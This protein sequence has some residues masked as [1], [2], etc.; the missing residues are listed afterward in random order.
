MLSISAVGNAGGAAS[1]YTDK[2]NYYFLGENST[3][4]FGKGAEQ[5]GLSGEKI[6]TN[7]FQSVLEG[8]LPDGGDL[9]FMK[10][11]A[12]I[13][14]GGYDLTFSAPKSVS[15]LA[16][17]E[18]EKD[19]LKAHQE[20]VRKTLG[21]I[22]TLFSTRSMVNGVPIQTQTGNM[23]GALFMHDTSRNLDP[24]LHT[25]AVIANATFDEI[26]GRWKTLSSDRIKSQNFVETD[27]TTNL[28]FKEKI[29]FGTIYRQFLKEE[30]VKQGYEIEVVG[31]N[32]LWEIKGVPTEIFSSRR[33]EILEAAR[34]NASAKSL[35]ITAQDTR[36]AKDFSNIEEVR[37]EW[38]EKLAETGFNLAQIRRTEQKD[39]MGN[40]TQAKPLE[41]SQNVKEAVEA[42][43]SSLE[44][45]SIKFSYSEILTRAMNRVEAKVGILA[46]VQSEVQK[47]TQ[48]GRIL[49]TDKQ[50]SIY[51]S[52][53]HLENERDV[54]IQA[55]ELRQKVSGIHEHGN[56]VI[57]MHLSE[58]QSQFTLFTIRGSNSYE[59]KVLNDLD[60]V[61]KANNQQPI[62]VTK[63]K[64]TKFELL[65][66]TEGKGDIYTLQ[67]YLQQDKKDK[68]RLVSV[69]Q[70]EKISLNEMK[71]LLSK[72][73]E[74]GD[75]LAV[76]DT[77]GRRFSGITRDV[78]ESAGMES[79][80]LTQSGDNNRL[81]VL[82]GV[83]KGDQVATAVKAYT[84][85]L[86]G[87]KNTILQTLNA[88]RAEVTNQV[89]EALQDYGYLSNNGVLLSTRESVYISDYQDRSKYKVG[90]VLEKTVQGKTETYKISGINKEKN[91]LILTAENGTNEEQTRKISL[92]ELNST[93]KVYQEK[94][95]DVRVGEHLKATS[96]F[97]ST[98]V[99]EELV[100]TGIKKGNF[101]FKEKLVLED[102]K[103]RE[104]KVPTDKTAYLSYNYVETHGSSK[105]QKR[106][107]IVA[108]VNQKD[109]STGMMTEIR[110]GAKDVLMITS[111]NSE[112]VQKN[113][114]IDDAKVTITDNLKT[115]FDAK[116]L[117][118]IQQASITKENNEL[119]RIV[120]TSIEKAMLETKD[121]VSFNAS[122]VE[123][124]V[125]SSTSFT[126]DQ[127][128]SYF[129]SRIE[130]GELIPLSQDEGISLNSMFVPLSG[131]RT[132]QAILALAAEQKGKSAP[133]LDKNNIGL[134]QE[135]VKGLTE[136]QKNYVSMVLTSQDGVSGVQGFPGVG[137]THALKTL[138]GLAEIYQPELE[139][140]ALSPTHQANKALRDA[141]IHEVS[142][143]QSFLKE[144]SSKN[145]SP[146]AFDKQF[147]VIDESSML[148]NKDLLA[149]MKVITE[150]GGRVTFLGDVQQL[151]SIESGTPLALL[152]QRG[153]MD[154]TEITQ[155][156]RQTQALRPV[157]EQTIA[158]Q[159][160][161]ALAKLSTISPD[162]V[163]RIEPQ[164][165]PS[166][167]VMN[168]EGEIQKNGK[169][170]EPKADLNAETVK[171]F[172]SRTPEARK[173]TLIVVPTNKASREINNLIHEE[174]VAQGEVTRSINVPTLQ[175]VNI[176]KADLQNP[177]TWKAYQDYTA[178]IGEQYYTV[179][180]VDQQGNVQII[181]QRTGDEKYINSYH[182]NAENAA[183]YQPFSIEVG[184]GDKVR[185]RITDKE[186]L[187]VNNSIGEVLSTEDGKLLINV[188][189]KQLSYDPSQDM[190]DRHFTL[191][192]S[193]TIYSSQG[194]NAQY[195]I[196]VFPQESTRYQELDS[197]LVAVSRGKE[198]IQVMS[199]DLTRLVDK[200]HQTGRGDR[201]TSLDLVEGREAEWDKIKED[202]NSVQEW[203][204]MVDSRIEWRQS[205]KLNDKAYDG[206]S[207]VVKESARYNV[208]K[209][210]LIF[211]VV[212]GEGQHQGNLHIPFNPMQG[213]L[214][215]AETYYSGGSD[216]SIVVLHKGDEQS[217]PKEYAFSELKEAIL[218]EGE[219][220]TVLLRL[221]EK[222][223]PITIALIEEDKVNTHIEKTLDEEKQSEQALDLR[224]DAEIQN[225]E[226]VF[227]NERENTQ[228]AER[229][230]SE[231]SRL[232]NDETNIVHHTKEN[233]TEEPRV[234][235][236]QEKE[237]L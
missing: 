11:G 181:D 166:A 168:F 23:L 70:S 187:V 221:P 76:L 156:V 165:M 5:L 16:L 204:K 152:L 133:I 219:E 88:K 140:K 119:E 155:I 198:H 8:K 201:A 205:L 36:Q 146:N 122:A 14:Q 12:N 9:S 6:D 66:T 190:S 191:G 186:R 202:R 29:A 49:V 218:S 182:V 32:G 189:G 53:A 184:V 19:L 26:T 161:T 145:L 7:L 154:K 10:N 93:W 81:I 185:F 51:T 192:Y 196:G 60:T 37:Q 43:I 193:S 89:R 52:S 118:E 131:L 164:N 224:L 141:G 150:H 18:G 42:V 123:T 197:F 222:D 90:Y 214:E 38:K 105:N 226:Q 61:A 136:G 50:H 28:I 175:Q 171:D 39:E 207:D 46:E 144:H 147:F 73:S 232:G 92:R 160:P 33:E 71:S 231:F 40:V 47:A 121:K 236:T 98:R 137:K 35:A 206:L 157:V 13:H 115:L 178:K 176:S 112:K 113:I 120:N 86:S 1:Y 126:R 69:Y 163:P 194:A 68:A 108:V 63:D 74:Q 149:V 94:E 130:S 199:D 96:S 116:D 56:T 95:L 3:E 117:K 85:L 230:E 78:V 212:N 143:Y 148:G 138:L 62:I 101:F 200:I 65:K 41:A 223:D 2:D 72:A 173:N 170:A 77:G 172:F 129:L 158:D 104:V 151:K 114:S 217:P 67:D 153:T 235:K 80:S 24:Q 21:E 106:D 64:H 25:H 99:N 211:Q 237:L 102:S 125:T 110:K 188:E 183:L 132:E 97:G 54:I 167:S 159:V 169:R 139:F 100:V 209:S 22:E 55:T 31:K 142:T 210:E 228:E 208:E 179:G 233:A 220:Q 107:T 75:T 27:A 82:E 203:S 84:T 213:K 177:L 58:S 15:V 17:V 44:K 59:A 109:T 128:R 195:V 48:S 45:E 57:G 83:D 216:G 124:L 174:Y 4:W 87:G 227:E 180:Q 91:Q 134:I 111:A 79:I 162:I 103:G 34:P 135:S 229:A 127:V 234:N 215:Y 225:N 30:V 20:A